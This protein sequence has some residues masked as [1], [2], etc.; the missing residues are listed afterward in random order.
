MAVDTVNIASVREKSGNNPLTSVELL[1]WKSQATATVASGMLISQVKL[2][3]LVSPSC[4]RRSSVEVEYNQQVDIFHKAT[5]KLYA[6]YLAL[7]RVCEKP[8]D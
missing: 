2:M 5:T 1:I 3:V 6:G 8:D 7:P 4:E